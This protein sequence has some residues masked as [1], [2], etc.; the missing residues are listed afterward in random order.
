MGPGKVIA[1]FSLVEL[2]TRAENLRKQ[3]DSVAQLIIDRGW[4]SFMTDYPIMDHDVVI[5]WIT[6]TDLR[7]R[8]SVHYIWDK[9]QAMW[10]IIIASVGEVHL[11]FPYPPGRDLT[12][13]DRVAL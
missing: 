12:G 6:E 10:E 4:W 13:L 7:P 9:E 3:L 8:V 2:Q 5:M 1:Q 11:S